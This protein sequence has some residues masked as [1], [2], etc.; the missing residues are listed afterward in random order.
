MTSAAWI[1]PDLTKVCKEGA[2]H[3]PC[4]STGFLSSA[5][6]AANCTTESFFT[7]AFLAE[8]TVDSTLVESDFDLAGGWFVIA[9]MS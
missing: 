2:S 4:R 5:T 8:N 6:S 9:A 7:D 1:F 3:L